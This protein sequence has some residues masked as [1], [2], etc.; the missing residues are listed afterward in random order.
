MSLPRGHFILVLH[1]HLPYVLGHGRWPHGTDW[2]AEA[3]VETYIPLLAALRRLA[4]DGIPPRITIGITPVLA[5]QLAHPAFRDEFRHYLTEKSRVAGEDA[6]SFRR[7][8]FARRAEL[9][10]R[11]VRIFD[12]TLRTFEDELGGDLIRAFRELQDGGQIE[13][14]T[15]GATHGYLPLLGRDSSVETQVRVG[16]Q[17]YRRHFGREPRGLW[18][19]EC[20]YRPRYAWRRPVDGGSGAPELRAGVDE[21]LSRN[22]LRFFVVDSHLLQGGKP[23]GVYLERFEALRELWLRASASMVERQIELA[24]TP[25][26][27]YLVMSD[28]AAGHA[29]VAILTRHPQVSLQVWSGEHGYP[30]DGAYLDF[31]KKHHTGGLRYWRV[32]GAKADLA[33]KL[34]YDPEA[35]AGRAREHAGHFV[36]LLESI[37][38]AYRR[39]HGRPG[40]V[41][42]P[43]DTELF[44]HWWHEGVDWI[45]AVLRRLAESEVVAATTASEHLEAAPATTVVSLPEGSWGEGGFHFIWLN[46]NTSWAWKHI[47]ADEDRMADLVVRYRQH[48]G[49][50]RSTDLLEVIR[51][52]GRELLLL[53]SSD[54]PFLISTR[55]ARDYAETRICRHHEAFERLAGI[56]ERLLGGGEMN[57]AD[58]VFLAETAERDDLFPDLEVDGFAARA[59]DRAGRGR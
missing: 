3:A 13:I 31:H 12:S 52:A 44:G 56:V 36:E 17:T 21:V 48:G 37:L 9:A 2:L 23:I 18:L 5:E 25:N 53:Q 55:S 35:A 33:D 42:A 34:E 30:G 22:G 51:Q 26:E 39:E 54:W 7:S 15:S 47:Y 6:A 50:G 58:R 28:P 4:H 46:E 20:A 11:W 41:C 45:E 59:S 32:T 57:A 38:A 29:P 19:P 24:K 8:G 16:C 27:A 10:E 43:F 40:L 14:I 1:S 49:G